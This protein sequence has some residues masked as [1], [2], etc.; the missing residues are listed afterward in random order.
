MIK[1]GVLYKKENGWVIVYLKAISIPLLI[2]KID[3]LNTYTEN[4]EI[5]F[6]IVSEK[7]GLKYAKV[8][9]KL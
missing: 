1:R 8:L 5:D 4:Q 3:K 9:K 6:E 2:N 7:D